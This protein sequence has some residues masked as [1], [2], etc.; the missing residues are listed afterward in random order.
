MPEGGR[1]V[2]TSGTHRSCGLEATRARLAGLLPRMGITR[3]SDV[4]GLDRIGIPA[5]MSV[6]PGSRGLSVQ[7]GKGLTLAAAMVSAMMES[8]ESFAAEQP[9]ANRLRTALA[10]HEDRLLPPANLLLR[11]LPPDAPIAW[12]AGHDLLANAPRHVP[13]AMVRFDV[14]LPRPESAHWFPA[15]TN[16]LA[17][18]NTAAEALLH[19]I[20]ELVERDAEALWRQAP[21]RRRA[22]TQCDPRTLGEAGVDWLLDRFAQAE[23]DVEVWD[24]TS[25][26]AVPAFACE[27]DD[28]LATG[29]YLGRSR[30]AGCHP[31]AAVA[32]CRA[33]SE[34]AQSRLTRIVGTRD[35]MDPRRY[36]DAEWH[37]DMAQLLH[38]PPVV[39]GRA[40]PA[41]RSFDGN[42]VEADLAA[43]LARLRAAGLTSLVA[44]DLSEEAL[45]M[46][47][48]RVIAP[49]LEGIR[50]PDHYRPGQRAAARARP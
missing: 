34:A 12:I 45:G 16:G 29:A 11:A 24:M 18:G 33:L 5:A 19:A 15:T 25:D 21:R 27:I 49:E 37:R 13:E 39:R 10:D 48:V 44:I 35:D 1:K 36:A 43:L 3:V 23:I 22:A 7:Q 9:M 17:A 50:H 30:G 38:D 26:L 31:S 14:T 41:A 2:L 28:R 20:C 47:C 4:T 42:T 32:L 8:V 6:R 46:P 40:A